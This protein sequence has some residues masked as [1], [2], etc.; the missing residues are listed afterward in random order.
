M[1]TSTTHSFE[2]LSAVRAIQGLLFIGSYFGRDVDVFGSNG[3][4]LMTFEM[5]EMTMK[6]VRFSDVSRGLGA[7]AFRRHWY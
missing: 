6:A 4:V 7:H 1:S 3:T 2:Q 5:A